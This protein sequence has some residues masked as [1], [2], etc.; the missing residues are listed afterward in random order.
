MSN[1]FYK[2]KPVQYKDFTPSDISIVPYRLR[3]SSFS[4]KFSIF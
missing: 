2:I 3:M 1:T 4:W